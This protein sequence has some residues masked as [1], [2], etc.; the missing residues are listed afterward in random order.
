MATTPVTDP[1]RGRNRFRPLI[2]GA[3]ALL[4]LLPAVAMQFTGEVNW[5]GSDFLV[6]GAML[7]TACGLYELAVW[8]SGDTVY[9]AAFGVA[10]FTGFLTVWVNLAVGML[11]SENNIENLM[12]AG[13]LLIAAV[14]AL[15]ANFRPRGMAWAMDAAALAQLLVCVIA[16]VIGFRERGVFLA[17]CFA[18]P[19]FA[20]AQL[21]R[22]AARDQEA[23]TTVQ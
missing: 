23:A 12:F 9:R 15:V 5:T 7:A 17:A 13:V 2:W 21:F 8:L 10:V 1:R 22:K 11:G 14:G 16:L 3:A 20:S 4:L 6:M 19:W 18:A